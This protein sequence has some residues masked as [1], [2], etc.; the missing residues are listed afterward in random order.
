MKRRITSLLAALTLAAF[1]IP[2]TAAVVSA[3]SGDVVATQTCQSWYVSVSLN[4]N[5]TSDR[6]VVVTTTIPGTTGIGGNHYDTSFGQIWDAS[7][8]AIS[9]G[10]VTLTI[11]NGT[12]VEFTTS[13]SLPTPSD[14]TVATASPSASA[15]TDPSESESPF[16]SFQG[17]TATPGSTTT[18]PPTNTGGN[19]SGDSSTPLLA[20]LIC[21]AFGG[22]GL[23]AVEAQR[24]SIR[25]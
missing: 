8:P 5:V 6:T 17:D 4:H 24:R 22:V 2:F 18:P 10:T 20:L 21:L 12:H 19:G 7:G 16:Q 15:S 1:A 11:Y 23:A 9:S 25:G 13:A 3:H 14:C